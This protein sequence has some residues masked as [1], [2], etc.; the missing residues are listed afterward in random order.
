MKARIGLDDP[1]VSALVAKRLEEDE[2][3]QERQF[4]LLRWDTHP[5][6]R[7]STVGTAK[8][9]NA[10]TAAKAGDWRALADLVD[11]GIVLIPAAR[12]LIAARL[13]SK[14]KKKGTR[15][16]SKKS[17]EERRLASAAI[18]ADEDYEL[19]WPV[20]REQFPK[21]RIGAVKARALAMAAERAGIAV[22]TLR[23][24]RKSKRYIGM[25][26]AP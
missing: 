8:Q 5:S 13:L 4:A 9:R 2:L 10:V 16:P 17:I 12:R 23:N 25:R 26:R 19:I 22:Q 3:E 6:V 1:A 18:G 11:R 21:E 20:L 14:I 15:G 7:P 24:Y